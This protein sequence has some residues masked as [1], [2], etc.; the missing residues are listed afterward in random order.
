MSAPRSALGRFAELIKFGHTV[1]ALPFALMAMLAAAAGWPSWRVL[2]WVLVCM[3][4]ARTSAMLFNRMAD[5]RMDRANP[6]TEG[7]HRL[8]PLAVVRGAWVV[9]LAVFV[10]ATTQL[11]LLCVVLAPVAVFLITFY[12][13]TKRFTWGCHFFLGLALAAAPM[14]GW[15]AVTGE[16]WSPVPWVLALGVMLWVAGFDIIYALLDVEYDRRWGMHSVPA[17]MGP[18]RARAVTRWL[19]VTAAVCFALF[20]WLAGLSWG[21]AVAWLLVVPALVGEQRMAAC[22]DPVRINRAFFH[23]NAVVG[24]L[25]VLGVWWD[26]CRS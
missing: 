9:S 12:S 2:F 21:Y 5:W 24:I 25:L 6:R 13:L 22:D 16:L 23:V 4:A 20:G 1:F 8:L 17:D 18:V 11:N 15:A 3:V 14:G 7:R 19:H 26:V 10:G